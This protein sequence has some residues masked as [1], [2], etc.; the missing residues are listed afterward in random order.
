VLLFFYKWSMSSLNVLST[1][2][3]TVAVFVV[4]DLLPIPHLA[5]ARRALVLLERRILGRSRDLSPTRHRRALHW[6]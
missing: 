2:I 3:A 4:L 5:K 6:F 1:L